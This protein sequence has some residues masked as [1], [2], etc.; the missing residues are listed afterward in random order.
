[1]RWARSTMMRRLARLDGDA[2]AQPTHGAGSLA[3]R[4]RTGLDRH[5]AKRRRDLRRAAVRRACP[6]HPPR[7]PLPPPHSF[8][9]GIPDARLALTR[10]APTFASCAGS[11]TWRRFAGSR[12]RCGATIDRW[13]FGFQRLADRLG[14]L[15][16]IG[17]GGAVLADARLVEATVLLG[18]VDDCVVLSGGLGRALIAAAPDAH[19][20]GALRIA[21]LDDLAAGEGA[22]A[23]RRFRL[24]RLLH[25]LDTAEDEQARERE[26]NHAPLVAASSTACPCSSSGTGRAGGSRGCGSDARW[27]RRHLARGRTGRCGRGACR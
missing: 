4:L 9:F 19:R 23:R 13:R 15:T 8:S 1:M 22:R 18:A 20:I 10:T 7:L 3:I 14:T 25:A 27:C 5:A 17:L 6:H 21:L 16:G 26:A 24:H 2:R 11:G 12:A